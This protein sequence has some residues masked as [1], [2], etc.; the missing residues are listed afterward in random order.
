MTLVPSCRAESSSSAKNEHKD[1]KAI[2]EAVPSKAK[3][4]FVPQTAGNH[5]SRALW[6]Q[7]TDSTAYW[8]A[9][10]AFLTE[11]FPVGARKKAR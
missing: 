8:T 7:F 10:E 6:E 5:G 11:N 9:V 4:D 2:F 3:V 1:W